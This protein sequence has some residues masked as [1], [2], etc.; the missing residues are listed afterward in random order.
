[1][2]KKLV[3]GTVSD[4]DNVETFE[5]KILDFAEQEGYFADIEADYIPEPDE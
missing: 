5:E 3:L 2:S 1:M 4:E